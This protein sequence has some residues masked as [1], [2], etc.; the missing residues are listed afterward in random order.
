MHLEKLAVISNRSAL[1][2]ER[3][4]PSSTVDPTI[5]VL[6]ERLDP[7]PAFVIGPYRDVL[8]WN[9]AWAALASPMGL[10]DRPVPNLAH[11]VFLDERA[12][13]VYVDWD[14]SADEQVNELR[15]ASMRWADD[16]PAALLEEL[17]G[18]PGFVDRWSADGVAV[19]RRGVHHL[20]HPELGEL[21]LA[22]EVLLLAD[23]DQ[24]L[25]TWL[26]ADATTTAA[27]ARHIPQP[28]S[29]AQLRVVGD[30]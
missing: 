27:L 6:L 26:P 11:Y 24:R 21:R 8:A 28:V 3:T 17:S 7:T 12:R 2:P 10:L 29:P 19:R 23:E 15:D 18:N 1:R 9:P 14:L 13:T 20:A 16:R 25:V 4:A 5:R 22:F 30:D